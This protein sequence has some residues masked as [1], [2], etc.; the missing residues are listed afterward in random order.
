LSMSGTELRP[1]YS[2]RAHTRILTDLD[3]HTHN[4]DILVTRQVSHLKLCLRLAVAAVSV[5]L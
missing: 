5:I 1:D 4:P 3:W 2:L